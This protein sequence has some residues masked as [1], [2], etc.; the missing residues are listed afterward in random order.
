MTRIGNVDQIMVLLRQQLQRMNKAGGKARSA[1]A[2]AAAK[3]ASRSAIERIAPL[4]KRDDLNERD[5]ERALVRAL[6]T[7]ELGSSL[8]EDYRFERVAG[9]VHRLLRSD[10]HARSLLAAAVDQARTRETG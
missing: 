9:E 3:S 1:N 4:A 7:D 2:S 6:L 8:A 5:F 10:E